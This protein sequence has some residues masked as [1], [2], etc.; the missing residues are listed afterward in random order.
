[1]MATKRQNLLEEKAMGG[2]KS[3]TKE[4]TEFRVARPDY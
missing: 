4:L 3:S 2:E 1:M